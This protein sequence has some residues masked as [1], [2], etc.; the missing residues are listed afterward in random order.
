[1]LSLAAI[2]S[3]WSL[4]RDSAAVSGSFSIKEVPRWVIIIVSGLTNSII[5]DTSGTDIFL[6]KGKIK[7]FMI[8]AS[9]DMILDINFEKNIMIVEP[10]AGLLDL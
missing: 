5:S 9:K 7:D 10:V 2:T 1:M 6:I 3:V 4:F 8:P